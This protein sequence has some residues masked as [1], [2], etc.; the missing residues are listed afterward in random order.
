MLP[1]EYDIFR[2]LIDVGEKFGFRKI[3]HEVNGYGTYGTYGI[4]DMVH[5]VRIVTLFVWYDMVRMVLFLLC[6]C[7][8]ARAS[9]EHARASEEHNRSNLRRYP[10]PQQKRL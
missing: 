2:S 8:H 4:V 5:M 6:D 10:P 9:A 3:I 7:E 1:V